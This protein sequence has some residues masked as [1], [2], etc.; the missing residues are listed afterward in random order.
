MMIMT[1]NCKDTVDAVLMVFANFDDKLKHFVSAIQSEDSQSCVLIE[2]L[3]NILAS[4]K[5][6]LEQK[7]K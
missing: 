7:V 1:P 4:V 2:F 6:K 3:I 5:I